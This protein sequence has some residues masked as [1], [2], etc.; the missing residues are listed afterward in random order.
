MQREITCNLVYHRCGRKCGPTGKYIRNI[1]RKLNSKIKHYIKRQKTYD[2]N[3]LLRAGAEDVLG[4]PHRRKLL[5]APRLEPHISKSK[6]FRAFEPYFL[7]GAIFAYY[8]AAFHS[9]TNSKMTLNDI[10]AT[11]I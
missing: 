5:Y 1:G 7:S 2:V 4:P 8:K 10:L 6:A 9:K 3:Q 11:F